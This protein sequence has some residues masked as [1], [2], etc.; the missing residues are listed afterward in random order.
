MA[1]DSGVELLGVEVEPAGRLQQP[2]AERR[3]PA[4]RSPISESAETSQKEQIRK[5]P[6]SPLQAVVGLLDLVAEDEAVLGQVVGDRLD[7]GAAPAGR[8]AGGSGAA[9]SAA[10]EASRASV[11]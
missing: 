2:L 9:G 5:V 11:S 6:S 4:A 3:A 7:R 10:V 1:P 8:R